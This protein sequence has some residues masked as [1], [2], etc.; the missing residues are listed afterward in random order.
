MQQHVQA[1]FAAKMHSELEMEDFF[2]SIR[3]QT[4]EKTNC[5]RMEAAKLSF[6][7]WDGDTSLFHGS[8][9]WGKERCPV[10]VSSFRHL[11]PKSPRELSYNQT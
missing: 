3:G 5:R 7:F 4:G 11:N 1:L 8:M 2:R 10:V 9:G 6:G